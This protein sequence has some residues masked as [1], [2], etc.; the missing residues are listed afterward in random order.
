MTTSYVRIA[1][2]VPDLVEHA[3]VVRDQERP[4]DDVPGAGRVGAGHEVLLPDGRGLVQ[5]VGPGGAPGTR[6]DVLT[7]ESAADGDG[8]RGVS[9][10]A[11][12]R[13]GAAPAARLGLQLHPLALARLGVR[14]LLVDRAAPLDVLFGAGADA[15]ARARTQLGT[16]HDEGAVRTLVDALAA[17]AARTADV[18]PDLGACADALAEVDRVR[19]L[20]SA[21]DLART[22]EVTVSDLH[23][24]W[25]TLVGIPPTSYLA[26]VRLTGFVREAVGPGPVTA[27]DVVGAVRWYAAAG[28]AP[29]EVE[30][31][32]GLTPVDLQR[33]ARR[34]A[35]LVG[36]PAA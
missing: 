32:T 25:V 13:H 21:A 31:F 8:V 7:G 36:L 19:G 22:L 18:S 24:W 1:T 34:T 4:R 35:A 2:A 14:D 17:R 30:R 6:T 15:V 9:T 29:R 23:R 26:A 5:L 27:A 11:V 3:W 12:V 33:L 16:G 28:Y 20:V 10:R